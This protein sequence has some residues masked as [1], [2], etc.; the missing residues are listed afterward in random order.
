MMTG[1]SQTHLEAGILRA[2]ILRPKTTRGIGCWNVQTLYQTGKL[3][4][5]I[6]EMDRNKMDW[7]WH[8]TV[9]NRPSDTIFREKRCSP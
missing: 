2:D 8:Q 1:D 4:Q 9:S 6:K 5:V 3:A 7:Q